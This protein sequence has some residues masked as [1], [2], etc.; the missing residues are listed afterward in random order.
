MMVRS[1]PSGSYYK[2]LVQIEIVRIGFAITSADG[3]TLKRC[4]MIF[5]LLMLYPSK[6]LTTIIKTMVSPSLIVRVSLG[7]KNGFMPFVFWALFSNPMVHKTETPHSCKHFTFSQ[8]RS[9]P[10]MIFVGP[11]VTNT[12]TNTN[13]FFNGG[14]SQLEVD[15]GSQPVH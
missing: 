6:C 10:Y 8:I 12:A 13:Q 14:G 15:Q 3:L 11:K 7:T 1:G 5:L 4:R 2:R 9:N